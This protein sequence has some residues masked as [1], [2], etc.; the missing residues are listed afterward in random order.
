MENIDQN[1]FQPTNTNN[2]NRSLKGNNIA[3]N[4]AIPKWRGSNKTPLVNIKEV[5]SDKSR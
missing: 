4:D 2:E 3:R 1:Q 5:A